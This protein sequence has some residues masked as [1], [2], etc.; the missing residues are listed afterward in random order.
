M[1]TITSKIIYLY[2]LAEYI[3][4][5]CSELDSETEPEAPARRT[6]A[7]APAEAQPET[8]AANLHNVTLYQ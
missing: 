7:A 3:P 1:E 5:P 4:G 8:Q 6:Q 2:L